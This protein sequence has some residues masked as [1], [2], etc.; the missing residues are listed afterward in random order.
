MS[1][2]AIEIRGLCKNYPAFA[3]KDINL[4]L[5]SGCIMGLIG[6]N[7]AGKTTTIKL[8]L[9]TVRKS[10]GS[11]KVLG[12]DSTDRKFHT[13]KEDVGIVLDEVSYPEA[14][15][16]KELRQIL[17]NSYRNWDDLAFGRY[18]ERL[19]LPE[20]RAFKEFSKGMKM[21]FGLAAALSHHPRLLILDEVTSGLDPVAREDVLEIFG[22]FTRTEDH[23]ILISSHIVGDLEKICDY[24]AFFHK[25]RELLCEEKDRLLETYGLLQGTKEQLDKCGRDA[26]VSSRETEYGVTALVRR[27]KLPSAMT[28]EPVSL[29]EIFVFMVKGR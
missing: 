21:K 24:I 25:G 3:L 14:M 23:S 1:E 11:V 6:E 10:G 26:V 2:N 16:I 12:R 17:K 22:D 4:T 5:P 9:G 13:V 8:L 18:M 20:K 15:T 29:E 27:D 7:G 19:E 28:P